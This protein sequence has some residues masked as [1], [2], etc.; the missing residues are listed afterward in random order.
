MKIP[1][2][3]KGDSPLYVGGQMVPAGETRHFEENE[4]PPEYKPAAE[5]PK[6]EEQADPL[7]EILAG[8]VKDILGDV[9]NMELA[10][11]QE[12][13]A[14]EQAAEKP[15][16]TLIEGLSAEILRRQAAALDGQDESEV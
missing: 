16:S 14:R 9:E 3:N 4:V 2:E 13:L 7:A 1:V 5:Q 12:L 6:P 15:R 11:V 10:G 8:T